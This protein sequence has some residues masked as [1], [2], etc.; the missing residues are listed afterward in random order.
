MFVLAPS[1]LS[2]LGLD[3]CRLYDLGA[4]NLVPSL[5]LALHHR[6]EYIEF[7]LDRGRNTLQNTIE[8]IR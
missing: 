5:H 4:K 8:I 7:P 3:W 6:G 1:A 2:F